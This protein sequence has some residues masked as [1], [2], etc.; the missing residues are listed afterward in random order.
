MTA[1]DWAEAAARFFEPH[2]RRWATP[3]DMARD[4]DPRTVQTPALDLIDR[5][6][7]DLLDTPDG[8]LIISMPPQEGKSQRTSRR[9]PLWALTQNPDLRIAVASYAHDVARRWGRVI[10]D[11]ITQHQHDLSL[12]IRADL[13][14]QHEWQLA[15]HEGGVFAV[16]IGGGLTGRPVDL[17]IIDDPIKDREQADSPTYRDRVW[18]WWTDVMATRLA[19]GAP[20]VLILTRWHHDDLAGRLLAAEDGHR[21][22]VV[23]IPAQAETD[24]DPLGRAPGEYMLSARGT[25]T[26]QWEAK[27]VQAGSRTWS[28]LFQGHPTPDEGGIFTRDL[29]R[30]YDMP[31][32]VT[33]GGTHL[34]PNVDLDTELVASWDLAFKSTASS[35]F[36]VGQVWLRRGANLYLLDQTRGRYSFTETVAEVRRLSSKWPQAVAKLVEDKANGPA[37]MDALSRTVHGLIPVN[38]EGG[39]IA[40]AQAVSPLIEA[41]NVHLPSPELA[42]WVGDLIEE[43]GQFPNGAHDDQVDALTQA[44]TRLSVRI[45]HNSRAT[46]GIVGIG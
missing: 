8:R 23:N 39:K 13:A 37:V 35:D 45:D 9:F 31:L 43:A 4:L 6:L 33:Q 21:W 46:A 14:A 28:S 7:V 34:I 30:E 5:A 40:R 16:G 18:D 27:R 36:V 19:P 15:G 10:R 25:T 44:I 38:P 32:W 17:A 12:A 3:G 42:P 11:D 1:L 41:G 22:Q 29:W 24:T 26:E 20:C 2:E